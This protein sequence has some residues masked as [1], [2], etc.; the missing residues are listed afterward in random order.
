MRLR[1][2]A[3]GAYEDVPRMP[4]GTPL[5]GDARNDENV[6]V[7]GLHAAFLSSTTA[8]GD[9]R[10]GDFKQARK[11]VTWHWQWIV[12][13]RVPAADDRRRRDRRV[14]RLAQALQ[15]VPGPVHPGRVPGRVVSVRPLAGAPVLPDELHRRGRRRPALRVRLRRDADH[16]PG[17]D[18]H[19]GRVRRRRPPHRLADLL[20]LPGRR[21]RRVHPPEQDDRHEA[22]L[23]RCSTS[24]PRPSAA[25]RTCCRCPAQPAPAPDLVDP[26]RPEDR[27]EGRRAGALH[28]RPR[29]PRPDPQGLPEVHPALVLR[30]RA[31][32]TSSTTA[33]AWARSAACSSAA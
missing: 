3:R 26:V 19:A 14:A 33:P 7:N 25:P 29:G 30:P 6:A 13:E 10:G 31:R 18:R 8:A 22:L 28:R 9:R 17:P 5:I 1:V 16:R 27:Q 21:A 12:L 24:R 15:E 11:L 4:D 20:P 32:P 23:A 2:G